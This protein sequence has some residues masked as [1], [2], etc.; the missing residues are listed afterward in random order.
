MWMPLVDLPDEVGSMHFAAGSHRIGHVSG[1]SI[2]D[3][4][5]REITQ[6][7]AERGLAVETYGALRAGDATF[8]AGWTLHSAGPNPTDELRAVMTVIYVADGMVVA[9]PANPFQELDRRLWLA[10]TPPG[11][12]VDSPLNPLLWPRS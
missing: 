10:D 6:L 5:D 11:S 9:A 4:S 12:P 8:H 7:V 1:E 3:E 2:S